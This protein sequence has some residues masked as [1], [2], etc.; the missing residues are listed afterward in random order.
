M[1]PETIYFSIIGRLMNLIKKR[2]GAVLLRYMERKGEWDY[3]SSFV[4]D[5]LSEVWKTNGSDHRSWLYLRAERSRYK[6]V[7][8][9]FEW[10][11]DGKK[12]DFFPYCV[13]LLLCY[14]PFRLF[15]S[16]QKKLDNAP[17]WFFD[18]MNIIDVGRLIEAEHG[19]SGM[20]IVFRMMNEIMPSADCGYI[21]NYWLDIDSWYESKFG[22]KR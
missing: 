22:K 9:D 2:R 14:D 12:I 11:L 18:R 3:S 15:F 8:T 21:H 13:D 20:R 10:E 7:R 19:L 5:I 17:F 4:P 1:K 6:V 16:D